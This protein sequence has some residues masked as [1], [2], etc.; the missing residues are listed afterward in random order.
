MNN[1]WHTILEK[2]RILDSEKTSSLEL[3]EFAKRDMA[4]EIDSERLG[5]RI[6]L[7]SNKEMSTQI[8]NDDPS[9]ITYTVNE[10]LNLIKLNPSL[11]DLKRIHEAKEIFNSQLVKVS[12]N[13][14]VSDTGM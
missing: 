7:C 4:I 10:V 12:L 13:D 2:R 14:E 11:K 9:A 6:W 3:S 8:R 1:I 5:C